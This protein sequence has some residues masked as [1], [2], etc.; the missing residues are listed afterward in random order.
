MGIPIFV[1]IVLSYTHHRSS[2]FRSVAADNIENKSLVPADVGPHE[3]KCDQHI[4][5]EGHSIHDG[6]VCQG[7]FEALCILG[8]QEDDVSICAFVVILSPLYLILVEVCPVLVEG[9]YG[10]V[11]NRG[12]VFALNKAD[13]CFCFSFSMATV[14]FKLTFQFPSIIQ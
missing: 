10:H 14:V 8:S 3:G 12:K 9:D 1:G 2:V 5:A 4:K 11:H 7:C 6:F 13:G